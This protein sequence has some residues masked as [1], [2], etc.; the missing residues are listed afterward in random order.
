MASGIRR[1]AALTFGCMS[2]PRRSSLTAS[3]GTDR[4]P[5]APPATAHHAS[6][7]SSPATT[8]SQCAADD[9]RRRRLNVRWSR[10][11]G[12]TPG[13]A[14]RRR[15]R[16]SAVDC[17]RARAG[18]DARRGPDGPI[19]PRRS[20]MRP[21]SGIPATPASA[22]VAAS[23]RLPK[24]STDVTSALTQARPSLRRPARLRR[25]RGAPVSRV[26]RIA[27]PARPR[28][29]RGRRRSGEKVTP[30]EC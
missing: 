2:G 5:G 11:G 8:L 14:A 4:L 26:Y 15:C 13:P 19:D 16:R 12:R 9:P 28:R 22:N 24:W 3:D 6:T 20:S 25:R 17:R 23:C 18:V 30:G 1:G 27:E 10:R 7:S 29:G 21:A